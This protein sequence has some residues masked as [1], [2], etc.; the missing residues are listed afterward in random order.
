MT[1]C[2]GISEYGVPIEE[3]YLT[4]DRF[5][6]L[7]PDLLPQFKSS[8]LWTWGLSYVRGDLDVNYF[9]KASP[10]QTVSAG[11]N[12][13]T[14]C[15][16][17]YHAMALKTDG[18]LWSWGAG[19]AGRLGNNS[20]VFQVYSPVQTISGGNDWKILSA[21]GSAS[22]AIKTD[23]TLW[24]WGYNGNGELGDFTRASKSSPVQTISGGTDWK[25]INHASFYRTTSVALKNDGSLWSWGCGRCWW[26]GNEN[27]INMSSP[28]QTITGG[29]NWKNAAVDYLTTGAIKT[30]GTLWMWGRN[31]NG[32]LGDFTNITKSSPVQNVS[33]ASNWKNLSLGTTSSSAIKTD[34]TLWLWG[35]WCVGTPT[36][37]SDV[38]LNLSSPVQ[39]I[40]G[41]TNW[42]K[43]SVYFSNAVA[44]KSDGTLWAW[45]NNCAR[46]LGYGD[47]SVCIDTPRRIFPAKTG[48]K[49]FSWARF[50]GNLIKE[51]GE[52]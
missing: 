5:F 39:I 45:G 27:T 40:N 35:R 20:T 13:K 49:N 10:V 8:S 31:G 52:M 22:G 26:H 36:V 38:N 15:V 28:V 21:G 37:L 42:K 11:N 12:W 14:T 6:D 30:D 50:G 23:G 7:Y 34:G 33:S 25:N 43:I 48:I 16:A 2:T 3:K 46:T 19:N 32:E 9:C 1:I 18:T 44:M 51:E 24:M 29:S 17:N 47:F 41:G 4:K